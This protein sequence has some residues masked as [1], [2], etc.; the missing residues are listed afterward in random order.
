[1]SGLISIKM[2][3]QQIAQPSKPSTIF[4]NAKTRRGSDSL[5]ALLWTAASRVFFSLLKA[6]QHG[7]YIG[8]GR[9]LKANKIS[10][11]QCK[12]MNLFTLIIIHSIKES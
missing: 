11:S 6:A 7:I 5:H 10:G 8:Y 3:S 9:D 1:M 12:F 4:A 2:D